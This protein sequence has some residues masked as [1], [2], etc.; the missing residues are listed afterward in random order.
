MA[1]KFWY[2]YNPH[3]KAPTR[4]HATLADAMKE[5]NRLAQEGIGMFYILEAIGMVQSIPKDVVIEVT[6]LKDY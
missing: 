2:V 6:T 4:Q 3:R 1:K 5:A